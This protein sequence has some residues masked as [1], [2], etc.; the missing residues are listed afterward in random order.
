M[1]ELLLRAVQV[2]GQRIVRLEY[3]FEEQAPHQAGQVRVKERGTG[4]VCGQAEGT[5]KIKERNKGR[6]Q[7]GRGVVEGVVEGG[8]EGG[9]MKYTLK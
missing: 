8:V 4:R 1:E 7:Q 5:R 9:L 3:A 2:G 6:T